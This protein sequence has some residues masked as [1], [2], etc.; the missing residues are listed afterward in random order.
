MKKFIFAMFMVVLMPLTGIIQPEKAHAESSAMEQRVEGLKFSTEPEN[1]KIF[2]S[3]DVKKSF[4]IWVSD[5]E[6]TLLVNCAKLPSDYELRVVELDLN[7][8]GFY[9]LRKITPEYER[10]KGNYSIPVKRVKKHS[11]FTIL[12]VQKKNPTIVVDYFHLPSKY[13]R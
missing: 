11:W 1:G 3:T 6:S 8:T 13:D 5:V 12:A 4:D 2:K 7:G 9:N 10:F